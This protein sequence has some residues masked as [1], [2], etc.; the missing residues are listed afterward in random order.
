MDLISALKT[1]RR[2][3]RAHPFTEFHEPR[4]M[5]SK[6][7]ILADDWEVEPQQKRK[8]KMWLYW[9]KRITDQG[10]CTIYSTPRFF[11]SDDDFINW[12]NAGVEFG[13]I[14]SSMIEIEEGE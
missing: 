3:K 12:I 4:E 2:I 9:Y 13:K 11:S 8:V 7:W 5:Y 6:E 10:I 1:G 14:E